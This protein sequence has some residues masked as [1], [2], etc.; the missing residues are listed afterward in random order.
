MLPKSDPVL[1]DTLKDWLHSESIKT[2][3]T[4]SSTEYNVVLVN[5][6]GGTVNTQI[7]KV[8]LDSSLAV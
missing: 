2:S 6:G 8:R 7:S 4:N 5:I 3:V 1:E